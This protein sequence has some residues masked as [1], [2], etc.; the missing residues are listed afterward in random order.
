MRWAGGVDL[1]MMS[2]AE[3]LDPAE[4]TFREYQRVV[5]PKYLD[6]IRT[7]AKQFSYG[8]VQYPMM[9]SLPAIARSHGREFADGLASAPIPTRA[10]P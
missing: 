5:D 4:G 9:H 1:S 8:V 6:Q 3:V 2:E 7:E 10:A